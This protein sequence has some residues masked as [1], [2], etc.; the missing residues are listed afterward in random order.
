[1]RSPRRWAI[2]RPVKSEPPP[3]ANGTTMR[4]GFAGYCWPVAGSAASATINAVQILSS[5]GMSPPAGALA[6]GSVRRV[7]LRENLLHVDGGEPA[8]LLEDAAVDHDEL[9][10][11]RLRRLDDQMRRIGEHAE[12]RMTRVQHNQVGAP[13]FGERGEELV[14]AARI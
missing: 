1:M 2:S 12:V 9:D 8:A 7:G 11:R 3:G 5:I 6:H 13:A 10:L 14:T 4:T